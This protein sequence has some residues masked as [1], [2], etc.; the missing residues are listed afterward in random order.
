LL[1][2]IWAPMESNLLSKN[3]KC[4]EMYNKGPYLQ[5]PFVRLGK[6]YR[7]TN[8]EQKYWDLL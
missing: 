2:K 1:T 6:M 4:V 8:E 5:G 7:D 3:N